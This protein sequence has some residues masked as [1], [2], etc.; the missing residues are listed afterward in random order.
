MLSFGFLCVCNIVDVVRAR[1]RVRVRACACVRVYVWVG[2]CVR[3]PVRVRACAC[4]CVWNGWNRL[5]FACLQEFCNGGALNRAIS[6]GVFKQ[7]GMKNRWKALMGVL[8]GIAKGMLHIHGKRIC[9]GDLNPANILLH[10]CANPLQS[11]PVV[12]EPLVA[13]PDAASGANHWATIWTAILSNPQQRPL[14][15]RMD[16]NMTLS[17]VIQHPPAAKCGRLSF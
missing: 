1:A 17:A 16:D 9:H 15:L 6:A 3:A 14:L 4:V 7:C 8:T 10:V 12:S 5:G 2:R 11:P 13:M